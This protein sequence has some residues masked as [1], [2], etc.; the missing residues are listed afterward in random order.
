MDDGWI[1]VHRCAIEHAI[2]QDDWLWR[3]WCWCLLKANH[4][5][6]NFQGTVVPRGSFITGKLRASEELGVTQ[7]KWWRGVQRLASPDY[8]CIHASANNRWTMITIV[9]YGTYQAEESRKQTR[10]N[11]QRTTNEQPTKPIEEQQ[12]QEEVR[13]VGRGPS[14]GK[15]PKQYDT[16][17]ISAAMDRFAEFYRHKHGE[18]FNVFQRQETYEDAMREGW[19]P[20]AFLVNI[21]ASIKGGWRG[22]YAKREAPA[23]QRPKQAEESPYKM[24]TV[25]PR[26][27]PQ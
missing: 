13:E 4:Q 18:Y 27:P 8:A 6:G 23:S 26:K 9:N 16:Q 2:F 17:E 7:S 25:P 22:V 12:E 15:I 14:G 10:A 20:E 3:L 1:K 19:T 21:S 24:L 11:N 5:D